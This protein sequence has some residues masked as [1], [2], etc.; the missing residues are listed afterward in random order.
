MTL[1]IPQESSWEI[2]INLEDGGYDSSVKELP[3]MMKVTGFSFTPIHN[4]IPRKQANAY[5]KSGDLISYGD[6]RFIALAGR[7]D[8]DLSNYANVP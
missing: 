6:Q 4:F 5:G 7:E 2:G 8:A 1:S 3:H